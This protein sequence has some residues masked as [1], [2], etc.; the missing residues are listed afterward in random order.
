MTAA[1]GKATGGLGCDNPQAARGR[2]RLLPFLE[3]IRS[4][5]AEWGEIPPFRDMLPDPGQ[6]QIE[7]GFTASAFS[8]KVPTEQEIMANA[9]IS[10]AASIGVILEGLRVLN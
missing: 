4:V 8:S 9:K 7:D 3:A 2:L 10:T 1:L 6:T 5:G